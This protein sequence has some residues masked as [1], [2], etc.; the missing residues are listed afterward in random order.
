MKKNTELDEIARRIEF[1][2]NSKSPIVKKIVAIAE[3]KIK[4][5]KMYENKEE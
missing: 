1:Y 4:E 2:R 5:T 3:K